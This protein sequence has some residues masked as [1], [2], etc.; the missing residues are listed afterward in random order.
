MGLQNSLD[1]VLLIF[2]DVAG[3]VGIAFEFSKKVAENGLRAELKAASCLAL[4]KDYTD[5]LLEESLVLLGCKIWLLKV[6]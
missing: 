3:H 2:E 6:L 1:G 4:L 5:N